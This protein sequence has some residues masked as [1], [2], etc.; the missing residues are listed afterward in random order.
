MCF[1]IP[2]PWL[3]SIQKIHAVKK[4]LYYWY[5]TK[6]TVPLSSMEIDLITSLPKES[7]SYSYEKDNH[8]IGWNQQK[9]SKYEII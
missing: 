2:L 9:S 5:A 7:Y 4:Y 8:G 3:I 1:T 6:Q